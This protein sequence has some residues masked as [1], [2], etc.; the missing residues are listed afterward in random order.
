[1][2]GLDAFP[3]WTNPNRVDLDSEFIY[4][5]CVQNDLGKQYRYIGRA[6]NE[7]R[8]R[9]YSRN[10]TRI[11]ARTPRGKYQR[12]RAIHFALA[13]ADEL[14]WAYEFYPLENFAG[15]DVNTREKE[16][17]LE[18]ECNLNGASTWPIEAYDSSDLEELIS[19]L[20]P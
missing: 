20:G 16:L 4:F 2:P 1:M 19:R 13:K 7:S 10:I 8:L 5:I 12:Y 18:N 6:R 17:I 14:G 9:E 15:R 11:R 3:M